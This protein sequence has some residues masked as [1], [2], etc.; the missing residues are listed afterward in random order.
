MPS[1]MSGTTGHSHNEVSGLRSISRKG[2]QITTRKLPI[3]T[4]KDIDIMANSL[5]IAPPEMIFGHNFVSINHNSGWN[6]SF[7]AFDALERVDK[8]GASMLKVAYSNEWQKSR[9]VLLI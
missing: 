5:G 4:S 7:N 9:F 2:F 1:S 3:L 8:S 6:I